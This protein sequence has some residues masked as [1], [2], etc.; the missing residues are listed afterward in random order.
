M[1][2][3]DDTTLEWLESK[4]LDLFDWMCLKLDTGRRRSRWDYE[5]LAAKYNRILLEERHSLRGQLQIEGGGPSKE[6][7]KLL[8]TK[9]PSLPLRHFVRT[10][11]EIGRNDIAQRLMPYV[12]QNVNSPPRLVI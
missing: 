1:F 12:K 8:Q 4:H 6:F 10:L 9:Y 5:R 3:L 11:T 2:Y 7:M